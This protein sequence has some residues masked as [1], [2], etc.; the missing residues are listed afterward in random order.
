MLEQKYTENEISGLKA[1]SKSDNLP[2][3]YY[4]LMGHVCQRNTEAL[5][6]YSVHLI[7]ILLCIKAVITFCNDF[8]FRK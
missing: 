3:W 8:F 7:Y 5:V 1:Q 6:R 4:T 2:T